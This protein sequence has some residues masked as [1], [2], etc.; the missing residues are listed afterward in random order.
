M[1]LRAAFLAAVLA[2]LA[3][4]ARMRL[5]P[6]ASAMGAIR[7]PAWIPSG[8]TLRLVSMGQRLLLSDLFWL[9]TVQYMG[10][11]FGAKVDRWAALY[12]LVDLVT[13]LDPRH[14]YAYQVAGSN[15]GGIAHRY[16]EADRILE[17]GMRNLPDRW[18]LPWTYA[19]NKYLFEGDF[20]TAARY[21]RVA[22]D[23][24]RR[25]HLALLAANLSL[26]TDDAA[27]YAAAT[28][29][30]EQAIGAATTDELREQLETRL[31]K[32]RTYE[33]LSRVERAIAA[34]Q[35]RWVRRPLALE[36]LVAA[37]LLEAVPADPAGGTIGY[38]LASGK[39]RSSALGE[40]RP[41]KN[42]MANR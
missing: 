16:D 34:F 39:V 5:Q 15:L 3:G 10:E 25:P 2:V 22:S 12:P 8:R 7:D 1:T 41:L 14:G 27:E 42:T 36:E 32:V 23:V 28:A 20:A 9:K 13:D 11:S 6:E 21:A 30:L 38:D 33:A 19:V 29:V 17:K 24:G 26:V 40:R 31:V 4:V 37:G 35:A 18:T